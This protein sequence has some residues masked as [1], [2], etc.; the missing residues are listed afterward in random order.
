MGETHWEG[1]EGDLVGVS[2]EMAF[3]NKKVLREEETY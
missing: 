3:V 2:L 1:E